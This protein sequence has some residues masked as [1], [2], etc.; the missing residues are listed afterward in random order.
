MVAVSLSR[1]Y[2][3]CEYPEAFM[4]SCQMYRLL[5][6][7]SSNAPSRMAEAYLHRDTTW[8]LYSSTHKPT[9]HF[10]PATYCAPFSRAY[11]PLSLPHR[12]L[13]HKLTDPAFQNKTADSRNLAL[14]V[15]CNILALG[16]SFLY[17]Q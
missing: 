9:L 1:L 13:Q 16:T 2:S 17:N 10:S 8:T 14:V 6:L 12:E 7:P 3:L 15:I 5:E 11:Q 4:S